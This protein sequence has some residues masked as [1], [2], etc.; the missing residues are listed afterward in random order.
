MS[1]WAIRS[2]PPAT[3]GAIR[4]QETGER[5]RLSVIVAALVGFG[6]TLAPVLAAA[7]AMG[8]SPA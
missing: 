3:G 7:T 1:A 4:R 6:G 2:R 8:A 5:M